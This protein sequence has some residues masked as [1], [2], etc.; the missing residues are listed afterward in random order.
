MAARC[1]LLQPRGSIQSESQEHDKM[2][3]IIDTTSETFEQEVLQAREPVLVDFSAPWC[4]PCRMLEPLLEQLAEE[5]AGRVKFVKVNVDN[6]LAVAERFDITGVPTV[7]IFTGGLII[8]TMVGLP[9]LR[10]LRETLKQ[11]TATPTKP[12]AV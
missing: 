11:V 6:A 1:N 8:G 9:A 7:M 4:G 10:T 12:V 2:S 3:N 5:F